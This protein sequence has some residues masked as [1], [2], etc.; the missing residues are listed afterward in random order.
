MRI[1]GAGLAAVIS[2]STCTV[3]LAADHELVLGYLA[4]KGTSYLEVAETISDRI[5]KATDGRVEIKINSSLLGGAA[6]APGIRDRQVDMGLVVD[7]YYAGTKPL[8]G[9]PA[10]PG[11]VNSLAEYR[12][13]MD[14]D[15]GAKFAEMWRA[16]F[17]S[18]SLMNVPF[19]PQILASVDAISTV[20][21]LS[22]KKLRVHNPE[23]GR[24]IAAAGAK[25]TALPA[26]EILPGL[27]QGVIDG[28]F[29]ASCW[30]EASGLPD[31]VT[32]VSEWK[33]AAYLPWE[34]L[35]N[36][37]SLGELPED[38]QK[39]ITDELAAWQG[40]LYDSYEARNQ[41]L[42]DKWRAHG[43]NYVVI[44]DAEISRLVGDEFSGPVYEAWYGAAEG[45]GLDGRALVESV[46]ASL[47]SN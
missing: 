8:L 6:L 13:L 28:V 4:F 47:K 44:D 33:V 5:S 16:D 25:P 43:T 41:D 20:D 9:V 42:A 46:R 38:L 37:D 1:V 21:E 26:A 24:L 35:I 22:G 30:A 45:A 3:A 32:H 27:Q 12:S 34:L 31:V 39:A 36:A 19:C 7:A 15:L 40:E 29:T 23:T 18:V 11:L 14:G 17:N 10:L 2:M